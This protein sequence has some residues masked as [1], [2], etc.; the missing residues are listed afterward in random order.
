MQVFGGKIVGLEEDFLGAADPI[1][2]LCLSYCHPSINGGNEE[3][4]EA[5]YSAWK[6]GDVHLAYFYSD[7]L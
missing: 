2:A 3:K 1:S 5:V 7:G 6:Y 4:S